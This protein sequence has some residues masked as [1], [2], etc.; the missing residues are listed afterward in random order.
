MNRLKEK[1][2]KKSML[3]EKDPYMSCKYPYQGIPI[4]VI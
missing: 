4:C 3:K 2:K 1:K